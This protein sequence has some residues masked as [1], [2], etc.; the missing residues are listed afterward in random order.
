M[1]HFVTLP[2]H[3]YTH[4]LLVTRLV[5]EGIAVGLQ[6]YATPPVRFCQ[7]QDTVILCDVE[8]FREADLKRLQRY[9]RH[10]EAA[11]TQVLN[12]PRRAMGRMRLINSLAAQGNG[13]RA[14]TASEFPSDARFPVFLRDEFEHSGPATEL[15]HASGQVAAA[16]RQYDRSRR[17]DGEPLVV[18][19]VD[20]R[21]RGD[22]RYHK[23]GAFFMDGTVV[24]RHLFFAKHWVVKRPDEQSK[25]DLAAER[26][27]LREN[28]H[29]DS[30][31]EACRRCGIDY[32]RVDF[33]A[34]S[35]GSIIVFEINTNPTV[36]HL[37]DFEQG[38]RQEVTENFYRAFKR[39][40]PMSR[41]AA[42]DS[43]SELSDKTVARQ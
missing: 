35:D 36:F 43:A 16:L 6:D 34:R 23:Y 4:D 22:D 19:F 31:A 10:C 20:I 11:G 1:I 40:L 26:E 18:E 30:V 37:E 28:H 27:Y 42:S 8:R 38:P 5:R 14:W 12:H 2:A 9:A 32:G 33:S 7:P 17:S 24:P 13:F 41:S 29:A 39:S 25:D 3:R 21:A 15:L